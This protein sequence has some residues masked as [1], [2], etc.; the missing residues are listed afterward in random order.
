[1]LTA[2]GFYRCRATLAAIYASTELHLLTDG[3]PGHT[4][5]WD[6]LERRLREAGL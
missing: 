3:S 6:Y 4:E 1:M 5:T 2:V